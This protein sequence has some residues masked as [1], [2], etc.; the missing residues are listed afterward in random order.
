MSPLVCKLRVEGTLIARKFC[1]RVVKIVHLFWSVSLAGM[2]FYSHLYFCGEKRNFRLYCIIFIWR[3]CFETVPIFVSIILLW[4]WM[5]N[6][7]SD[8]MIRYDNIRK[9]EYWNCMRENCA[10]TSCNIDKAQ[11]YYQIIHVASTDFMVND[12]LHL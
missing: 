6:R 2:N 4:P 3:D 11:Q 9:R 12:L 8:R 5:R 7:E 10:L 1:S